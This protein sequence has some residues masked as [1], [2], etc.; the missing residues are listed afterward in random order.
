MGCSTS[1]RR[2]P[3]SRCCATSPTGRGVG[4]ARVRECIERA[5]E[6]GRHRVVLS[7]QASMHAAHAIYERFGFRRAPERDWSP[8]G[9]LRLLVYVLELD[10]E[11][12]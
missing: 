2:T 10:A 12:A 1:A 11:R 7:T 6:L 9:D 5:R 3:T 4:T 8:V